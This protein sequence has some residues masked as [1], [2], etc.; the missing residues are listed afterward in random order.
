MLLRRFGVDALDRIEDAVQTAFARAVSSWP[1]RGVPDNPT[2]WLAVVARNR[3]LDELRRRETAHDHREPIAA[4]ARRLEPSPDEEM[5]PL[6]DDGLRLI[7]LC[8]DPRL[9][10]REA[11]SM[12]LRLACGL[13]AGEIAAALL[14]EESAVRKAITRAKRR[15]RDGTPRFP[16]P[17]QEALGSRLDRVLEILYL[18]FN[19]GYAAHSGPNLVR[20]EMCAEA[21]RLVEILIAAPIDDTST[22][23][24]LA[25]LMCFQAS[26]L[27]ARVAA[28]GSLVRLAEQDRSLWD[29]SLIRRG[30]EHLR[31]TTTGST[32]TAY[33]L[34][35]AIAACHAAASSDDATDWARIR[36]LYDDL[37]ALH[38]SP[39]VSLNRSVALTRVEGPER[40][41][42]ELQA[43]ESEGR[44]ADNHLLPALIADNLQRL[45][46]SGEAAAYY[47]RA[48]D[49]V[50]TRPERQFLTDQLNACFTGYEDGSS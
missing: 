4:A 42:E 49:R 40:G 47:R 36:S 19:E 25:A 8:C 11:V 37:A 44:L 20:C 28:D 17:G 18:L 10:D 15:L 13:T 12:T 1:E 24:S 41:L 2:A 16:T 38:P 22:L 43:L 48:L 21:T 6:E 50:I 29:A 5:S 46:R 26:R 3:L 9:S 45:G 35:A 7:L 34:E 30:F 39:I 33:H 32:R 23:H 27:P 14:R 31:R